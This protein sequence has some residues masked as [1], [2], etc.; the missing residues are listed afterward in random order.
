MGHAT[1]RV[2][3]FELDGCAVLARPPPCSQTRTAAPRSPS[4]DDDEPPEKER[5]LPYARGQPRML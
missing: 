1:W 2:F 4:S 5:R 3:F